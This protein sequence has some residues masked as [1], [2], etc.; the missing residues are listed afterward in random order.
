MNKTLTSKI[1]C[2]I[3]CYYWAGI[4]GNENF[5]SSA[6]NDI[7]IFINGDDND[8][9]LSQMSVDSS[10]TNKMKYFDF[11][12]RTARLPE[13]TLN[14]DFMQILSD[15]GSSI[16]K[17]EDMYIYFMLPYYDDLSYNNIHVY[18][19]IDMGVGGFEK[20]NKPIEVIDNNG[21]ISNYALYR[22]SQ[23]QN[24]FINIKIG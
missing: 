23:K 14:P 9:N 3:K 19:S 18:A 7:D 4:K 24:G 20:Y 1:K 16:E 10:L 2:L 13:T 5:S 21:R 6:L 22:T 8:Y 11:E 12:D 17:I 15:D